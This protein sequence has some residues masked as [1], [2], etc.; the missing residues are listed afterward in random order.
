MS[1]PC[2]HRTR[3]VAGKSSIRATRC[4]RDRPQGRAGAH[5]VGGFKIRG[6]FAKLAFRPITQFLPS[7]HHP[8][9][10]YRPCWGSVRA[11][12]GTGRKTQSLSAGPCVQ[13]MGDL[14][15][16]KFCVGSPRTLRAI[17]QRRSRRQRIGQCQRVGLRSRARCFC[18]MPSC[19]PCQH[20]PRFSGAQWYLSVA[21]GSKS[22]HPSGHPSCYT[23]DGIL[24][25]TVLP[26]RF[27]VVCQKS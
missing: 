3:A 8:R 4:R 20:A 10:T 15:V 21:N 17:L 14:S 27:A 19:A 9:Q 12:C 1:S 11:A 23:R 16:R 2:L 26:I 13:P 24:P 22:V 25:A 6:A 5:F 18:V 7:H